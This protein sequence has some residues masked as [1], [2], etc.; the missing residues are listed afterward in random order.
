MHNGGN[1]GD[2]HRNLKYYIQN[3]KTSLKSTYKLNIFY[4]T[5][6]KTER[7]LTVLDNLN[8]LKVHYFVSSFT[9]NILLY[10]YFSKFLLRFVL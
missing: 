7:R 1:N 10:K 2:I 5:N 4:K 9:K 3:F 6:L 8:V